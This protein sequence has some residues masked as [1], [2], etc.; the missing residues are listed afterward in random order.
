MSSDDERDTDDTGIKMEASASIQHRKSMRC[1]FIIDL[2]DIK[3][4]LIDRGGNDDIPWIFYID[5]SEL[6]QFQSAAGFFP[7]HVSGE[8]EHQDDITEGCVF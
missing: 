7:V 1:Q 4:F 6:K 8:T 2:I 3:L 5:F